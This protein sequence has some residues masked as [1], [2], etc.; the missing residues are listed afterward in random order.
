MN[1]FMTE[2]LK[3]ELTKSGNGTISGLM[4]TQQTP[5]ITATQQDK[6]N[7]TPQNSQQMSLEKFQD[8]L[9]NIYLNKNKNNPA[10]D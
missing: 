3:S 1:P 4:P 10:G 7:A 8:M 2:L 9:K 6:N 5:N